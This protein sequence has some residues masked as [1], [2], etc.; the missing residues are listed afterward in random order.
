MIGRANAVASGI[1]VDTSASQQVHEQSRTPAG[2]RGNGVPILHLNS[3]NMY[4]GV[5]TILATL[6]RLRASC[7]GMEPHYA[8]CHDGRLARELVAAGVPVHILG[9][10]RLSRPW[11]V[12][13]ARRRLRGI[14]ERQRFDLVVCHMPWS[15]A[16]FGPAVRRAGQPLGFW[17][18]AFHHGRNWLERLARLT[19][20]DVVIAN[21]G[22]TA[23]GIQ[24]LFAGV[25][26]EIVYPPVALTRSPEENQWRAAVREQYGVPEDTVVIIQVSRMEE[27]KG[28]FP[29]LEALAQLKD[30]P[31]HWVCW[32][33]GGAQD[34]EQQQYLSRLQRRTSELG[35]DKVVRFTGQRADVPTLLAAADI[36]CQPNSSPD[37]FGIV[38]VEAMWAGLP[39]VTSGIGGALEVVD[40]SCGLL[41]KPGDGVGLTAAL[42]SLI[43]SARQRQLLGQ[44]GR[45]RAPQLCDAATQMRVLCNLVQST[46]EGMGRS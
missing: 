38:F 5:E 19:R 2:V 18:H 25:P 31:Q 6:A 29:H 21:S 7:P 41:V 16:V 45:Q 12:W 40:S 22:S 44:G 23:S 46:N 4:G 32:M 30:L 26:S 39:V 15:L 3:G 1:S 37:S 33:V 9:N 17:A 27:C 8:L 42:R 11:T 36:F 35:L 34:P 28:H 24:N 10:V 14:L 13:R 20:P 43:Q